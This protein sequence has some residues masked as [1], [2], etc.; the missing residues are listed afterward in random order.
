M[1][2]WIRRDSDHDGIKDLQ[3]SGDDVSMPV[4]NGIKGSW[5]D[6]NLHNT[7]ESVDAEGEIPYK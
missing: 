7:D 3:A 5:I 6:A 2:G 1:L 4:S